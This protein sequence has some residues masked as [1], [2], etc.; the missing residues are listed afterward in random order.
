MNKNVA[1]VKNLQNLDDRNTT[2]MFVACK[3]KWRFLE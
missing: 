2:G 3:C 1:T